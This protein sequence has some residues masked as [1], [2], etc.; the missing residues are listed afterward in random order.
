MGIKLGIM[1][2]HNDNPIIFHEFLKIKEH[3]LSELK[4]SKLVLNIEI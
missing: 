3:H 2:G 1:P 4:I